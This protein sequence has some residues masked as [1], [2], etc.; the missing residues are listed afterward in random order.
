M[1][2]AFRAAALHHH[3]ELLVP[4]HTV[5]GQLAADAG[6]ALAVA[7]HEGGQRHQ[8]V[9]V[10]VRHV[11]GAEA[12]AVVLGDEAGVEVARHELRVRQQRAWNGMLLLMPRITKP[13]SAARIL[14]M[15]SL[16]SARAR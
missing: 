13:F 1:P 3:H 16:R 7:A 2:A 6:G 11:L 12:L 9:R 10:V 15:A 5:A 14:A 4:I 8:E